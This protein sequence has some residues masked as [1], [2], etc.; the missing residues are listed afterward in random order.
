[1][2]T[3]YQE[4]EPKLIAALAIA[5]VTA[6]LYLGVSLAPTPW[7]DRLAQQLD[8]VK[9]GHETALRGA[10]HPGLGLFGLF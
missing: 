6:T 5:A 7:R 9:A 8:G 1:L 10:D 4:F 3:S 2:A